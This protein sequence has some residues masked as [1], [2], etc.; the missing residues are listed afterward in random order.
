MAPTSR[1]KSE[2]ERLEETVRAVRPQGGTRTARLEASP[3]LVR[4]ASRLERPV[5]E[6]LLR[7]STDTVRRTKY[8][9]IEDLKADG[10]IVYT[11]PHG[12]KEGPL[13]R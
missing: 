1:S 11:E 9:V 2:P 6:I 8:P 3:L 12:I 10:T 7:I 5:N 4:I 13:S